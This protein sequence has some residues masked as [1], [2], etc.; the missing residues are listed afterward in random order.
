MS[1]PV[2]VDAR[3]RYMRVVISRFAP[4]VMSSISEEWTVEASGCQEWLEFRGL[5]EQ[6]TA[7]TSSVGSEEVQKIRDLLDGLLYLWDEEPM[8]N[9]YYPYKAAELI[10]LHCRMAIGDLRDDAPVSLSEWIERF[11][12]HV[13]WQLAKSGVDL[14]EVSYFRHLENRFQSDRRELVNP[15]SSVFE[16]LMTKSKEASLAYVNALTAALGG[17]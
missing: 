13:D 6:V 10:E 3:I 1:I 17:R 5:V 8:G 14:G 15:A 11:A 2:D 4:I 9:T 7:T 16:E 12:G